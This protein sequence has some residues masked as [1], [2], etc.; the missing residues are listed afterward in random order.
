MYLGCPSSLED[1]AS[2]AGQL[3][4]WAKDFQAVQGVPGGLQGTA[5]AGRGRPLRR[6]LSLGA[7]GLEP[8]QLG[9]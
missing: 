3:E 5:A 7:T 8:L 6:F 9:S 1:A 2:L 4:R